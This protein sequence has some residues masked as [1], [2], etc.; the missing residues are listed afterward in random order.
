MKK[1]QMVDLQTQYEFIK[2]NVDNSVLE[3]MKNGTFINGPSVSEFQSNLESYLNVKHVIPCANGTDALQI[4]LMSLGLKPGDEIITSDFTFAATVEVIALL[5]LTPVLVDVD[6]DTFNIDCDKVIQAITSK[7]KAIIPVHLFG[8]V[9]NMEKLISIA[10][11]HNLF[12]IEDNAQGIGSTYEFSNNTKVKSGAIGDIGTTSF[13]P[14]KN[15]GCFGDGGAIFTN[16]DDLAHT[17]RGI[18]NHGMY[19][20]YHHDV[21]GVN[22]RLDSIQAAV[23]N[24]K[25]PLLDFYNERRK[26]ASLFY[27]KRFESNQYLITPIVTGNC[28]SHVFHQYT[29]RVIN[30]MRDALADYLSELKIP[31]GIYYPIPLHRQ[32]AYIDIRYNENDFKISNL[33]S[34]QVISLPMHSEL[35]EDQIDF[36]CEK[37]NN[38]FKDQDS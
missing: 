16:D 17:I 31:F 10:K 23:L 28:Q 2:D 7:T 37:I 38:F 20:R 6:I 5:R 35:E 24:T 8:Q 30:G 32:K 22:S 21:V 36:I 3:V 34:E 11:T 26:Q 19:K 33:M 18:V 1:I 14:S 25:L 27:S 9:A 4:A 15:L 12:L 13:F 29:L